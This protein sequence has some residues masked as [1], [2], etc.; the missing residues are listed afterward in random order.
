MNRQTKGRGADSKRATLADTDPVRWV[1]DALNLPLVLEK[2]HRAVPL[3]RAA[4]HRL[5]LDFHGSLAKAISLLT[6]I[7]SNDEELQK[8]LTHG[9][10]FG[11]SSDAI[12]DPATGRRYRLAISRNA[13]DQLRA[14][15]SETSDQKVPTSAEH[16]ARVTNAVLHELERTLVSLYGTAQH[17]ASVD[18]ARKN[19]L[20][21]KFA[22]T[23]GDSLSAVSSIRDGK[24]A[25]SHD[26][27]PTGTIASELVRALSP[28]AN[29]KN[30]RLQLDIPAD[31]RFPGGYSDLRSILW[32]LTQN[33]IEAVTPGGAV[34]VCAQ[35]TGEVVRISV[36]DDGPGIDPEIRSRV[37]ERQYSTK[38]NASGLGL[39]EVRR[40]VR[41]LGGVVRIDEGVRRGTTI[42]VD[43][44]I[45][46]PATQDAAATQDAGTTQ[47]AAATQD[48]GRSS[49][50]RV[51]QPL[52]D[53]RILVISEPLDGSIEHLRAQG[54]CV[55][56]MA[57]EQLAD[58]HWLPGDGLFDVALAPYGDGLLSGAAIC[59]QAKTFAKRVILVSESSALANEVDAIIPLD[60]SPE[61]LIA[62]VL[63]AT[64]LDRT[65]SQ[66][67][68]DKL[69]TES[70]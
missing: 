42:V 20:I 18:G 28:L 67:E 37:F 39:S 58:G 70:I 63:G 9:R 51:R 17:A 40:A 54:A 36:A 41:K 34:R 19:E 43:L 45:E 57:S 69:Q 64:H 12:I 15:I 21:E 25:G 66:R 61:H 46:K 11:E 30:A 56:D 10:H 44:P 13:D 29:H 1:A 14:L 5:G 65:P 48:A 23:I 2:D 49:I 8:L 59:V 31:L 35:D 38:N 3:N 50:V 4:R 33:A 16:E 47:D 7:P 52:S 24:T 55:E 60:C 27:P 6:G 22:Q 53:L 62:M 26:E 68:F 32:N